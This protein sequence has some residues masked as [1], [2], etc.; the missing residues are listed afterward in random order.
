MYTVNNID[1]SQVKNIDISQ[2]DLQVIDGIVLYIRYNKIQKVGKQL[3]WRGKFTSELMDVP[4]KSCAPICLMIDGLQ[5]FYFDEDLMRDVGVHLQLN[6]PDE[7]QSS[8]LM[9]QR[10]TMCRKMLK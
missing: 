4:R 9:S 2:R 6:I 3:Y 7:P 1:I 8:T 10:C 5:K